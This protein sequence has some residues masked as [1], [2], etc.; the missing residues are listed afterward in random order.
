MDAASYLEE[1]AL[2]AREAGRNLIAQ[3]AESLADRVRR[4]AFYVA[5]VG[6][7][8]RGKS[9]VLDALLG[10]SILPVGVVPITAVPTIV[11]YG[12]RDARVNLKERGW[13]SIGIEEVESYISEVENPENSKGVGAVEIFLPD[14][15]LEQGV[16]LV[17]TPGLGSVFDMNTEATR[18]FVPHIDA[19]VV[20]LGADPPI[21]ADELEFVTQLSQHVDDLIF[22][23][24]KA[25]RI[26]ASDV[27][28]A[29]Q[30]ATDILSRRLGK[31]VTIFEVAAKE[32]LELRNQSRDWL[33]L[34][35]AV[36]HL[37]SSSRERL[38]EQASRRGVAR[39][40]KSFHESLIDEHETLTGPM[41]ILR[42]RER[43]MDELVSKTEETLLDLATL[44][45]AEQRRAIQS[46][47]DRRRK[48]LQS[49]EIE[50]GGELFE[51]MT[52][53]EIWGPIY[54]RNLFERAQE[55]SQ[56]RVDDWLITEGAEL[57]ADYQK[58]RLRFVG[59]ANDLLESLL[60]SDVE[61]VDRAVDV[62]QASPELSRRSRFQFMSAMNIARPA[63][64]FRYLLDII[65]TIT[66]RREAIRQDAQN[67]LSYL[68]DA[69]TSRVQRDLED[70]LTA[71]RNDLERLIRRTLGESIEAARTTLD[72][73]EATRRDGDAAV[74]AEVEQLK[75]WEQRLMN[76][77][78]AHGLERAVA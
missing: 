61:G 27:A 18:Q 14:E 60:E 29:K 45:N 43:H 10:E 17:D 62:L 34:V 42:T 3:D 12:E 35:C 50:A 48:W 33:K 76:L 71:T 7:F 38:I 36:A 8:K 56:S 53:R 24:N 75:S 11:R 78:E 2:L 41:E 32:Q 65:L 4:S 16:C 23:L 28:E 6:Q 77:A 49:A 40:T 69:N 26:P 13:Q 58:I 20:V 9:T 67:F 37:A 30:F 46:I 52:E 66:G 72:R 39:L 25:D 54:R 31:P 51:A 1:L 55:V 68:L 21:T 47:D 15:L 74:A 19:A 57:E 64:P 59:I 73:I 22:V 70:R 44:L 5:F 63:S